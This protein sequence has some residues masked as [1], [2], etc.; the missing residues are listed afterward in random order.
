MVGVKQAKGWLGVGS[1]VNAASSAADKPR[2]AR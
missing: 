2:L 1:A